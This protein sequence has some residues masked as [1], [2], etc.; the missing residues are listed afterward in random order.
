E[1]RK[2][3]IPGEVGKGEE[4]KQAEPVIEESQTEISNGGVVQETEGVINKSNI[5]EKVNDQKGRQEGL[6]RTEVISPSEEGAVPTEVIEEVEPK[7]GISVE[8]FKKLDEGKELDLP[9]EKVKVAKDIH[10]NFDEIIQGMVDNGD[11]KIDCEL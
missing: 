11:L 9:E 3:P 5:N 8:D 6:L 10:D 2:E 7:E 4:L 1:N